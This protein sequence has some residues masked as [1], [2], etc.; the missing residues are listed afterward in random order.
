MS[1]RMPRTG[2]MLLAAALV[3]LGIGATLLEAEAQRGG[4]RGGG[5]ARAGGAARAGGGTR[6]NV[7]RS[8]NANVNRNVN[9]NVNR[10]VNVDVDHHYHRGGYGYGGY[11]VARA[12]G[13]TAA[14]AVT[15]A[16]IGSMVYSLPPSCQ[17]VVTSGVTYHQCGSSWYQPRYSGTQ[18]TYVVV[19][20]P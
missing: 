19:D 1:F 14:V 20:P 18:T 12:V 9:A 3:T 10:N 7:N 11:P 8:A 13:A 5:G 15:A 6:T 2:A 17:T 4:G 16:A